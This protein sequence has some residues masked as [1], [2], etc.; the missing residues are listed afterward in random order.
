MGHYFCLHWIKRLHSSAGVTTTSLFL[1]PPTLSHDCTWENWAWSLAWK[2]GACPAGSLRFHTELTFPGHLKI[3]V[4]SSLEGCHGSYFLMVFTDSCWDDWLLSC[5]DKIL[6]FLSLLGA[7]FLL[8]INSKIS[9]SFFW[10]EGLMSFLDT[11]RVH[12]WGH[13]WWFWTNQVSSSYEGSMISGTRVFVGHQ[14][15]IQWCSRAR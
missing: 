7:L 1:M 4:L 12:T 9:V 14:S 5:L 15:H 2:E 10:G 13:T 8:F 11:L 6:I 3:L